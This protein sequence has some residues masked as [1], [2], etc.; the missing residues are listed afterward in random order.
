MPELTLTIPPDK[1]TLAD[2]LL[3]AE[4]VR[5]KLRRE[6]NA[7]GA[8]FERGVI[9]KAEWE[10]YLKDDYEPR[11]NAVGNAILG[12]RAEPKDAARAAS[13]DALKSIVLATTFQVTAEAKALGD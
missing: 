7:W 13:D 10:A 5:E 2:R 6:H 12:L 11:D 1:T 9:M 8:A 3:Y 4:Q